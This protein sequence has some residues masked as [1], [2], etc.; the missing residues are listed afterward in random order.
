VR[1][2]ELVNELGAPSG[3]VVHVPLTPSRD[4]LVAE[5]LE[6]VESVLQDELEWKARGCVAVW[7]IAN[8]NVHGLS[9]S[10]SELNKRLVP[11]LLEQQEPARGHRW[12]CQEA[13]RRNQKGTV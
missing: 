3:V 4:G 9:V 7:L 1:P 2:S 10:L 8:A 5:P 13:N 6:G 11:N 12:L